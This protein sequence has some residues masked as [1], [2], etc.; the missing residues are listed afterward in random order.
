MRTSKHGVL[1]SMCLPA[2][3]GVR[4]R[5]MHVGSLADDHLWLCTAALKSADCS[6]EPWIYLWGTVPKRM[7]VG[8]CT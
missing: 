5:E 1:V 4:L 8:V 2:R 6:C 3:S 7:R